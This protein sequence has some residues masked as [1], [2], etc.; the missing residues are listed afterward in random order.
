[1][2]PNIDLIKLDLINVDSLGTHG[3]NG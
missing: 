3:Q 1:M 2:L